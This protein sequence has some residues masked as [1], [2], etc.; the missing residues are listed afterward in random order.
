M[1]AVLWA[2]IVGWGLQTGVVRQL[3]MLIGVYGAALL[4]G[5][6][7]RSV[8][9]AMALA[10]GREN[11]PLLEFAAYV[12][13]FVVAFGVIGLVLWRAYP[14]SRL[15]QLFGTE[16]VLGAAIGAVWG[17]LLLIVLLTMLRYF[18][19]V[20]W[21]EQEVSQRNVIGQIRSSQVAPVLEVV[22]SPLWQVLV[23]WF[24]ERVDPRL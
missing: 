23:P 6:V 16:N 18:T 1:F 21:R 2:G 19:V 8:G 3:G 13:T 10:F 20:P 14:I 11:Q 17:V 15:G 24:P 5:S 7:Y 4:A 12:A 22:A 9:Q